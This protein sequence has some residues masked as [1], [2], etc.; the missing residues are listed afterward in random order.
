MREADGS[1]ARDGHADIAAIVVTYDSARDLGPLLA[2]LRRE[3]TTLA[4]RV[5]VADNSP[6]DATLRVARAHPDVIAVPTGGNLGYAGG[7]NAGAEHVGDAESV[8]VLNPDLRVRE[9]ALDA[10]LGALRADARRGAVVPRIVDAGGRTSASLFREPT[11]SRALGDALLGRLWRRR[12]PALSESVRDPRAYERAHDVDW[13]T[14]AAILLSATAMARVG[15]WDERY[16]LYSEETDYLRRV[17]DAGWRVHFTP[18]AVVAH[19]Q[20]GSG[21]S[22]ALECLLEVN[23]VRYMRAH[24][25]RRA[26][27]YRAAR[28]LGTALRAPW[29]ARNRH[30]VA[31]LCRES[32][33][34]RLPAATWRGDGSPA[35]AVVIPAHNEAAVIERT[36]A[37]LREPA[38]AGSLEVLVVCNGC[39][40]D[41]AA[42]ARRFTG[43]RVL[44]MTE[45]SKP[46]ALNA[47]IAA[48]RVRPVIVLDADIELPPSAIPGVLRALRRP[49]VL[50]ARPP[51]AYDVSSAGPLVRAYYRAR[52]RVPELSAA[53]WGAGVYALAPEGERRVA[54]FPL[55]TADDVHVETTLAGTTAIPPLAAVR[56]RVPT[57]TRDLLATLVR[58][59]RGPA[60]LGIDTGRRT[61]R[62]LLRTIAGPASARDA[63][64][65]A[66][67]AAV[68]R[69][70]ASRSRPGA[71]ERDASS[72]VAAA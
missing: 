40:D 19:A 11:L 45:G 67:L 51:F 52:T 37:R 15:E 50:A 32:R 1:F 46:R 64:V 47:G 22:S 12:P 39:T 56:V 66:V 9:G 31:A 63:V 30:L 68:A 61:M 27:L 72:R 57:T 65:Y 48:A 4:L 24:A 53:M 5:I 71:W 17:R 7:I 18:A 6:D 58:V 26:G 70:R 20:G 49:A 23:R 13:A 35:A 55:V 54:P 36:L 41:T 8:L 3:A 34:D 21:T 59:R 16:F 62:G 43:V 25:P 28:L 44:E 42:R 69:R 33:W 14:G 38:A 60:E 2:T 10:M 29:S